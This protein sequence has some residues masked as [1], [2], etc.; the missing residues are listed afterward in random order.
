METI[1]IKLLKGLVVLTFLALFLYQAILINK[2]SI[3][4]DGLKDA[5]AQ[6]E[7]LY[8][9][10]ETS[11]NSQQVNIEQ[12]KSGYNFG[13]YINLQSERNIPENGKSEEG[14][15]EEI[16]DIDEI[17][18]ENGL[19]N[20]V[21]PKEQSYSSLVEPILDDNS[22]L[23]NNEK[24]VVNVTQEQQVAF[25]LLISKLDDSMY[26]STLNFSKFSQAKEFTSLP[27]PLQMLLLNKV[28]NLYHSGYINQQ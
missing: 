22:T 5:Q 26:V 6:N 21:L 7:L 2:L 19:K 15:H 13:Q 17:N 11:L 23:V 14:I 9:D 4:I 27:K 3:S 10:I 28:A 25:E 1:H 16:S 12:L 8:S 24:I 20:V 18:N